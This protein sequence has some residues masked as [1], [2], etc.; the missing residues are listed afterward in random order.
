MASVNNDPGRDRWAMRRAL[1]PAPALILVL[2]AGCKGSP[3]RDEEREGGSIGPPGTTEVRVK[4][5]SV[6]GYD[7]PE[8][9]W[10]CDY[11]VVETAGRYEAG[12]RGRATVPKE[13]VDLLLECLG[14]KRQQCLLFFDP[15]ADV[16][17]V[18]VEDKEVMA[19]LKEAQGK[20]HERQ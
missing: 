10:F 4:L 9:R 18:G 1:L 20:P 3:Q 7:V 12:Q 19:E 2:L 13:H 8:Q 5:R 15:A 14:N 17:A 11:E 6:G 16:V